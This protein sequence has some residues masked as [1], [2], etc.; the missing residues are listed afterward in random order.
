L[1]TYLTGR[2][3]K[4]H[5][6]F[7]F[8]TLLFL[9]LACQISSPVSAQ[10]FEGAPEGVYEVA[11]PDAKLSLL[12]RQALAEVRE[13][14][15]SRYLYLARAGSIFQKKYYRRGPP[16]IKPIA[17]WTQGDLWWFRTEYDQFATQR[18][19]LEKWSAIE[20]AIMVDT[21]ASDGGGE[22]EGEGAE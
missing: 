20:L 1:L 12:Q 13:K 18:D 14:D 22:G 5:I 10:G 15:R 4:M 9:A 16:L 19:D 17:Q 7:L 11:D 21:I 8:P 2:T 3:L 6:S